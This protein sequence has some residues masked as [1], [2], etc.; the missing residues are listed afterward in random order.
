MKLPNKYKY[1]IGMFALGILLTILFSIGFIVF[2]AIVGTD[3]GWGL[4]W[5]AIGA[6]WL[7]ILSVVLG[8][9]GFIIDKVKAK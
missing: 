6:F 4:M 2:L 9:I 3:G 7:G 5:L 8:I 1:T